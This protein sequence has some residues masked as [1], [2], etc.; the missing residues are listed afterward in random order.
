[1]KRGDNHANIQQSE[2]CPQGKTLLPERC[3]TCHRNLSSQHQQYRTGR[4]L[5]LSGNSTPNGKVFQGA[6][7]RTFYPDRGITDIRITEDSLRYFTP[8]H[9]V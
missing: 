1:M 6:G 2:K 5:P 9:I 3:G 7:R 8:S 4:V